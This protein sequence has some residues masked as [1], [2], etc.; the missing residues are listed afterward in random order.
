[1]LCMTSKHHSW[2]PKVEII[3]SV[4]VWFIGQPFVKRFALCY[5]TIVLSVCLSC[6]V[7][8]VRA[9]WPN[10]WT[11]QDEPW[12]AGRPRTWPHCVRWGPSYPSP[13]WAQ[14]PNF[15]PISVVAKW[16][17]GSRCPGDFVL[18]GDLARRS[19]PKEGRRPQIFGPCLLGPNGWMDQDGTWHGGRPQPRR[20]CV[21]P[22]RPPKFSFHV[23]Y[24]YC[25]FVRTLHT[26]YWFVQVQVQVLV[27]YAFYF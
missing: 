6:P 26:R 13:K 23:Y 20:L 7:C 11:D 25:D 5:R 27:F 14:P 19:L 8:D 3:L 15:R 16:L 9:L 2:K 10:G 22:S 17:H 12:R 18:D 21:R 4:I 1:M 24:S